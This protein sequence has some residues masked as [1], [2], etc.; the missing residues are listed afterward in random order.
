M[1]RDKRQL[2]LDALLRDLVCLLGKPLLQLLEREAAVRDPVL[3]GLIHLG[4]A[5]FIY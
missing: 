1:W 4:V 2:P 5:A 3:R